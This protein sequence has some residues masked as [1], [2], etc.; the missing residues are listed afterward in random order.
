MLAAGA[1]RA[2]CGPFAG[3][4]CDD[5]G[6]VDVHQA[7][8]KAENLSVTLLA[9]LSGKHCMSQLA[10]S[11]RTFAQPPACQGPVHPRR[12]CAEAGTSL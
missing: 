9:S 3:L 11:E 7:A 8:Y 10:F 12:A 2:A 4:L 6:M 1:S 5:V